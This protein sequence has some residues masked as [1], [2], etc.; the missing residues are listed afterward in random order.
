M[1]ALVAFA[2]AVGNPGVRHERSQGLDGAGLGD[3][4]Q[5]RT[6]AAFALYVVVLRYVHHR[7]RVLQ[8][9]PSGGAVDNVAELVHRVAPVAEALRAPGTLERVVGVR[10]GCLRPDG[11][12]PHVTV[13]ARGLLLVRVEV[14]QVSEG[15]IRG[16]IEWI[17]IAEDDGLLG[18]RAG[19]HHYQSH[20]ERPGL[21]QSPMNLV[22]NNTLTEWDSGRRDK[23]LG[24][25]ACNAHTQANSEV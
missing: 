23:G 5:A 18:T 21:P 20:R 12:D 10:V 16:R 3:V 22:H 24:G 1:R 17:A 6:V 11:L 4:V 8:G 2:T 7:V 9:V 15:E 19:D 25:V 13:S 14:S